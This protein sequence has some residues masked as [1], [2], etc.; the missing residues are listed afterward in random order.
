MKRKQFLTAG[1]LSIPLISLRGIAGGDRTKAPFVVPANK[2]KNNNVDYFQGR[3][4]NNLKI[5]GQDTDDALCMFEYVGVDKIG[6]P[7]HVHFKQDEVF[8]VVSGRFRFVVGDRTELLTAGD[9]IFLPRDIPHTWVQ[10]SDEGRMI[11]L[12]SPAGKFER[13][14]DKLNSLKG[15]LSPQ[16]LDQITL[17][18][19]MKNVGPPLQP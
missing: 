3:N 12:L 1:L 16:E 14:F 5:S 11:Y 17:E 13:F 8:V 9:T 4:L 2:N 19:D 18:H 15:P 7:M 10:L 6:P